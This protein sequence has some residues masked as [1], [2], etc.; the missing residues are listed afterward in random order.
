MMVNAQVY[1]RQILEEKWWGQYKS[2][3]DDESSAK[4]ILS[5][6]TD[7]GNANIS[8][9][10]DYRTNI[11]YHWGVFS[12]DL[13][14]FQR[15]LENRR[16]YV[17]FKNYLRRAAMKIRIDKGKKVKDGAILTVINGVTVIVDRLV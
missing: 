16:V 17:Q 6:S 5:S 4:M 8:C 14:N 13:I 1:A 3:M 11:R 15:G 7:V 2:F 9:G 12:F 10:K